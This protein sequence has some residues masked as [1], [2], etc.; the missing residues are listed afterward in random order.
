MSAE[1]RAVARVGRGTPA[2]T[3]RFLLCHGCSEKPTHG[4]ETTEDEKRSNSRNSSR[5]S[6]ADRDRTARGLKTCRNSWARRSSRHRKT[7][8]PPIHRMSTRIDVV[9][10]WTAANRYRLRTRWSRRA[11]RCRGEEVLTSEERVDKRRRPGRRQEGEGRQQQ[12]RQQ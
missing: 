3:F 2:T 7:K 6:P 5:A 8:P 9:S 4:R 12:H 11:P 10:H 1:G